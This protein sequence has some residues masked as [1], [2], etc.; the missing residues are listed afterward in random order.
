[1]KASTKQ[2]IK[3]LGITIFILIVLNILGTLFFH[4][5]DLTKDKRYTLSPTSLG[6]IKQVQ[7]P[8]SIKIYM[9]GDLPADFRRLQRRNKTIIRR[10]SGLQ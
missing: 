4:R 9:E 10:I 5:F 8:L 6:I 3:T 2:N 7:N 1:M